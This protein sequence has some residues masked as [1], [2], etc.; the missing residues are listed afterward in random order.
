MDTY[1]QYLIDTFQKYRPSPKYP[2]YP[3]YHTGLYLEDYLFESFIKDNI[4]YD[5]Y[6]IPVFWTSCYVDE[7]WQGLQDLI[8]QLD[9]NKKYFCVT[10]HDDAI[11][12]I[13]PIDTMEFN[14]G[15]N[16][17]GIPIPLICSSI[18]NN[19][20][21]Q[22]LERDILCSFIG[23]MTHP[24]RKYLFE[25]YGDTTHNQSFY[26]GNKN[27]TPTVDD[28]DLKHFINITSRS[29][30]TL[31]PRGYGKSSFRL[32]ESMQLGSIPIY[33]YDQPWVPFEDKID[34]TEFSILIHY[35]QLRELK[36]ILLS[37]NKEKIDTMR[38]KMI[39]IY[40][41]NFTLKSTCDNIKNTLLNG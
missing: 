6:Y 32:Y 28:S 4:Q 26:F 8:N 23:S 7:C 14:A 10:Q 35:T 9:K 41:D 3:P 24:I 5:R 36:N 16:G 34:W 38:E 25:L 39:K 12:E 31:C 40:Q 27:W 22:N 15:G 37:Y 19:I 2:V 33:I 17:G 20:K 18:P 1:Q 21:P 11:R 13:M 29:L 30:F